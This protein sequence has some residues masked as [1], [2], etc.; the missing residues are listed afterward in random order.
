MNKI[1]KRILISSI[2]VSCIVFLLFALTYHDYHREMS[3]TKERLLTSEILKTP[4]GEIEYAVKGEGTP[5]LLLHGAGGGYDQGVILSRVFLSDDFRVIAPS[6]FGFLRTPLPENASFAAQ[7]DAY[8]DLLDELNISKVAIIGISA[9]G[10]SSLEFALRHP[11]RVSSMVLVSAVVH[12]EKPMDF[13][14][15]IIHYV[16][17]K[18]DFLFWMIAKN[19]ESS[20]ISFFGVT[21]EVQANLTPDE[22]HWLSNVFIPALHP[23]SQRQGGMLNDQNNFPFLDY[24]LDEITVP[25]LI[26][27]AGD[28]TLVNPS[29]SQYAAQKIPSAKVI[30]LESGGH[31]LM[32]QHERVRSEMVKFLKQHATNGTQGWR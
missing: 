21:P 15:K 10:P 6:R 11:D 2:I 32:G 5:V 1:R 24:Q 4:N 3:L 8:I 26:V 18:S 7:A 27:Y 19:F 16:I 13:K 25:T 9:G 17:F 14:G 22:K 23:I 28:D 30:T 31:M 20:L 29:H 12:K